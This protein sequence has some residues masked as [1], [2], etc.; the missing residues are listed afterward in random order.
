M[1]QTGFPGACIG[2]TGIDHQ[3]A[4]VI[5]RRKMLLAQLHWRCTKTV[6]REDHANN[7]ARL[8]CDDG[9]VFAICLAYTG[10]G[11]AYG[12]TGDRMQILRAGDV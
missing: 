4:Y 2:D 8:Q 7:S 10:L 5:A 1:L 3:S 11:H 6:L 9:Q 12:H